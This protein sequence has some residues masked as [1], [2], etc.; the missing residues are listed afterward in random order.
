MELYIEFITKEWMLFAALALTRRL[1]IHNLLSGGAKNNVEPSQATE[2]INRQDAV[3]VD[4]RPIND[5][6]QGHI[7]AAINIPAGSLKNQIGTLEKH[8]Q[9]PLII[10]CRSG[11]QSVAACKQLSSAGF[12]SVYNLKG[13]MMRGAV[14]TC[15]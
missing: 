2:M 13:G 15:R 14:Q 6:G 5:F 12:E 1:L 7:I 8:K 4:I 3:V 9:K 10:A 11:S